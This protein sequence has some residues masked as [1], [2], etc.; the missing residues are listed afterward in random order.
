ME[1]DISE[2][3]RIF[4]LLTTS[5][6]WCGILQEALEVEKRKEE[7]YKAA[8]YGAFIGW[9]WFMVHSPIPTLHRMVAEK[10]LDITL[11]TRSSK[12]FK[13]RNPELIAE[14][15]AFFEKA[16]KEAE[17]T[18][19]IPD[20]LFSSVVGYDNIKNL[21]R[22]AVT[23]ESPAH[24]LLSGAPASAKT[25][26]LLELHRL[27]DSYYCVDEKTECLSIDGWKTY[28]DLQVGELILT[29]DPATG[30]LE[31][32]PIQKLHIYPNYSDLAVEFKARHFSALTTLE[33]RW[34]TSD[35]QVD[36][37]RFMSS[38][39]L[40]EARHFYRIH[41]VGEYVGAKTSPYSD[42]EIE[43]I[44]WLLTDGSFCRAWKSTRIAIYQSTSSRFVGE[45]DLLFTRLGIKHNRKTYSG[46]IHWTFYG[47][48]V[49]R[50]K[51]EFPSKQLTSSFLSSLTAPQI[52]LLHNT[53]MKGDGSGNG[54]MGHFYQLKKESADMFQML[55]TL[56]GKA[57]SLYSRGHP[58]RVAKSPKVP[59][60]IN[61]KLSWVVGVQKRKF[62]NNRSGNQGI[63]HY[64][65]TM[66]CPS[67]SN[68]TFMARREGHVYVTGNSLAPTLSSAGLANLLFVYQ[69]HYLIIDEIDRLPG[70]ELGQLNSL[71]AT[72][73]IVETKYGK[74]RSIDLKT[75]V[76]AA[77]I[78]VD[79]LPKDLL[80]RFI[81][82]RFLAY[83]EKEFLQVT[84][85]VLTTREGLVPERSE[86]IGRAVWQMYGE[87]S[88]VRL[89]VS[90]ARLISSKPES[91]KEVLQTL[92]KCG[93]GTESFRDLI[94]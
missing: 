90:I 73:R 76:F 69:P 46:I 61:E 92:K 51:S 86:E 30:F 63:I 67:T 77:G 21:L 33:H 1:S 39:R 54:D 65:G 91:L 49:K 75:K 9:E 38:K 13:V 17:K 80:S 74:T 8:G 82:L 55:A 94:R 50:L 58:G 41:R 84:T 10:L 16:G 12:H 70:T 15:L 66:W 59:W 71:M 42:D 11:S 88:D 28:N 34:L 83:T 57:T 56:A 87:Q 81:K 18:T 3:L 72:G 64:N 36:K 79:R 32:K 44:G 43:L 2:R 52:T 85:T 26:F 20:D 25:L 78:R 31:W 89:C 53:M 40:A 35:G 23:A 24:V 5:P 19:E 37:A 45:I 7:E 22:L 68:G 29:K 27:P 93:W 47:K 48:L 60:G 6:D 14:A 62:A 4:N